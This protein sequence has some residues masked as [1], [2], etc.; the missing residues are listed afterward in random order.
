MNKAIVYN[1]ILEL[2]RKTGQGLPVFL[3]RR[4]SEMYD[5]AK[6]LLK[7][8]LIIEHTKEYRTLPD[9]ITYQIKGAYYPEVGTDLVNLRVFLGVPHGIPGDKRTNGDLLRSLDFVKEYYSWLSA[10]IDHIERSLKIPSMEE[11]PEEPTEVIEYLTSTEWYSGNLS[12]GKCLDRLSNVRDLLEK[13]VAT[14][15]LIC[16]L[17]ADAG[18]E[19]SNTKKEISDAEK[20]ICLITGSITFLRNLSVGENTPIQDCVLC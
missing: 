18:S 17:E 3:V 5:H 15:K 1:N 9:D 7:E 6:N 20:K 2:Y 13:L 19:T 8:G 11:A 12:V 14:K 10:N 4:S 16:D